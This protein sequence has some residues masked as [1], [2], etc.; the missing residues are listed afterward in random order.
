MTTFLSLTLF[1]MV[2]LGGFIALA[3][4]LALILRTRKLLSFA[5]ILV[6]ALLLIHFLAPV[7]QFITSLSH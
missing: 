5:V 1:Q 7:A 3:C 4:A 2:F 6:A